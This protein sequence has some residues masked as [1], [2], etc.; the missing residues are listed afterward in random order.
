MFEHIFQSTD[1]YELLDQEYQLNRLSNDKIYE[2][3]KKEK[4]LNTAMAY[5]M[6]YLVMVAW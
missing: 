2:L 5:K 6:Q 3:Y 4:I 1:Y